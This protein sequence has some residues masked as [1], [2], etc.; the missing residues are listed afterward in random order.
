MAPD[1]QFRFNSNMPIL[2]GVELNQPLKMKSKY[3]SIVF[4]SLFLWLAVACQPSGDSQTAEAD[5]APAEEATEAVADEAAE[6]VGDEAE[7]SSFQQFQALFQN[8]T[9]DP[10]SK[11]LSDEL[12]GGGN[13]RPVKV[14]NNQTDIFIYEVADFYLAES[15][16]VYTFSM[17]GQRLDQKV[18]FSSEGGELYNYNLEITGINS[19]EFRG[20]L[21]LSL[22]DESIFGVMSEEEK[23]SLEKEKVDYY[24]VDRQGI[25]TKLYAPDIAEI[26]EAA[27]TLSNIE[28]IY[29]NLQPEE[30]RPSAYGSLMNHKGE[31]KD[32]LA[33]INA[34][35]GFYQFDVANG[36]LSFKL[37]ASQPIDE[38]TARQIVYWNLEDG[39]KL[40]ALATRV[41]A[42]VCEGSAIEFFYADESNALTP[43]AYSE[44]IPD[45]GMKSWAKNPEDEMVCDYFTVLYNLPQQGKNIEVQVESECSCCEM[46]GN[47]VTLEWNNGTFTFGEFASI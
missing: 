16:V 20:T 46:K 21:D 22:Y 4:L 28:Q 38:E 13:Y 18:I 29:L 34:D 24:Q 47:S 19:F 1:C 14:I 12:L 41:C 44:I 17:D 8:I 9:G 7:V 32:G 31:T 15:S 36:Y 2:R 42:F 23:Q 33:Y 10:I 5:E 25:I 30:Q 35:I 45:L 27:S 3:Q 26:N 11:E 39:R 43:V 37:N 6:A 40:V